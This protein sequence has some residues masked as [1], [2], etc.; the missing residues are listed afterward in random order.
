MASKKYRKYELIYLIQPEATDDE[1]QKVH[2]RV[3]NVITEGD[4][5]LLTREDWGKRKLA[6]EIRKQNKAYYTYMTLL[7]TPGVTT[8]IERIL[9]LV[10]N[11]IRFITIK[12][13]DGIP[14]DQAQAMGTTPTAPDAAEG[15]DAEEE[16]TN[17]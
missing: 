10:D 5:W 9:R 12:L 14:E 17:V 1:R 2:D 4:A 13:E 8:E 15:D 3:E 6:Y 7:A 11:C 16:A